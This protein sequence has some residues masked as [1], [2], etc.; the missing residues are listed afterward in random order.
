MR[1]IAANAAS[2]DMTN[3]KVGSQQTNA[4]IANPMIYENAIVDEDDDSQDVEMDRNDD[5]EFVGEMEI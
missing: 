1:E 5:S 3:N 4:G 2:N